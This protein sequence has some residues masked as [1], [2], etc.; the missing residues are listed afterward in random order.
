MR[1]GIVGI[2][3]RRVV[4]YIATIRADAK[5]VMKRNNAKGGTVRTG[6]LTAVGG[7]TVMG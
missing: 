3:V 5:Q 2:A 6:D 7:G 1:Q 4:D